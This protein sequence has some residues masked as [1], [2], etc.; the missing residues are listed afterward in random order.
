MEIIPIQNNHVVIY[1][2]ILHNHGQV[3]DELLANL[4]KKPVSLD[5]TYN[6]ERPYRLF[7]YHLIKEIYTNK[8]N[9]DIPN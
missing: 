9:D 6:Q 8:S 1:Q 5:F 3:D 2:Q 7:E 4:N